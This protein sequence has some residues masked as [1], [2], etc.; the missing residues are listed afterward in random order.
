MEAMTAI[1]IMAPAPLC[2]GMTIK[3]YGA[4]SGGFSMVTGGSNNSIICPSP[5][6]SIA[7]DYS[8][9]EE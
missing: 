1:L 3:T 6:L 9:H 5:F 2:S 7:V 8:G 4:A